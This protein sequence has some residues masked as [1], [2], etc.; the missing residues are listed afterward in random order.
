MTK[1]LLKL[2]IMATATGLLATGCATTNVTKATK[3][4]PITYKIGQGGAQFASLT[5]KD[6]TSRPQLPRYDGSDAAQPRGAQGRRFDP[7]KVDRQLYSHQKVGRRYTIMGRSYT[8]KHQPDYDRTGEASWYGPKF[9]GK[10]T[11]NGETF[12]KRAMTAAHKTLPL[13]SIVVVTNLEN[14]RVITVRLNDRGPF[15][16]DRMIDL[17]EAA[18]EALGYKQNGLAKVRVQY[19]GPADPMASDR[20]IEPALPRMV[21][22]PQ[23]NIVEVPR[24]APRRAS[25][26]A[27]NPLIPE[28]TAPQ[29]PDPILPVAPRRAAEGD[30]PEGDITLTIKG[31]IH[32]AKADEAD[33]KPKFISE[34]L[35]TK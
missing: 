30:L 13:N 10:P 4:A 18:A 2:T 34:R 8:P 26:P 33:P 19:A 29:T 31:P 32:I 22:L 7:S 23:D 20:R 9:H 24:P 6:R 16:G 11:A 25:P 15:I 21:E 17:S 5:L 27:T 1:P 35:K 3:M 14:G 28:F 12:D